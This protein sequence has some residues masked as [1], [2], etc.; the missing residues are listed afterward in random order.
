[1]SALS[2]IFTIT[3]TLIREG[4][5][6]YRRSRARFASRLKVLD[7]SCQSRGEVGHRMAGVNCQISCVTSC[8]GI[9]MAHAWAMREN[10]CDLVENIYS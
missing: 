9:I 3:G 7:A 10:V 6:W 5:N 1:M 4:W 2:R 8:V